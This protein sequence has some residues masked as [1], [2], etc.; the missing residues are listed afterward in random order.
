MTWCVIYAVA[1]GVAKCVCSRANGRKYSG[2][3]EGLYLF[4]QTLSTCME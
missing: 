3:G 1:S 4:G 2:N